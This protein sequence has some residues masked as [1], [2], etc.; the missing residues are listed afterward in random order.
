MA[1]DPK[2]SIEIERL[3]DDKY[4]KAM[5]SSLLHINGCQYNLCYCIVGFLLLACLAI[6]I[7]VDVALRINPE[8]PLYVDSTCK[9]TTRVYQDETINRI[10]ELTKPFRFKKVKSRPPDQPI[11]F[12]GTHHKTGTFLA[13]K[14]FSQ[15]CADLKLC[16]ILEPSRMTETKTLDDLTEGNPDLLGHFSW[17][18]FPEELADNYRFVHFY[19]D[20]PKKVISGYR[21]HAEG[22]EN[23]SKRPS[24]WYKTCSKDPAEKCKTIYLGK[25]ACKAMLGV[26]QS[27]LSRHPDILKPTSMLEKGDALICSHLSQ[28]PQQLNSSGN[29]SVLSKNLFDLPLEKGLLIEAG[30]EFYE[31]LSMADIVNHTRSD[32]NSLN[33]NLDDMMSDFEGFARRILEFINLHNGDTKLFEKM[34]RQMNFFDVKTSSLYNWAM[35]T[36]LFNHVAND[37]NI[38]FDKEAAEMFLLNDPLFQSVYKPVIE[39]IGE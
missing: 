22:V 28:M 8:I 15:I 34:V 2:I 23:W 36:P 13:K 25:H 5:R 39:L 29:L 14:I 20:I 33:I 21:Y 12:V 35:G 4:Q 7:C 27:E 38:F 1:A 6:Y 10:D 31:D 11:I 26:K 18:W 9:D 3:S 16:C 19:R 37:K 17:Q 32:P 24:P 30:L